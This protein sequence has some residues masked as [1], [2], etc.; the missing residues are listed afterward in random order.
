MPYIKCPDGK[1]Y[2]RYDQSDYA[3]WCICNE[4]AQRDKIFTECMEDPTCKKEYLHNQD[5][6]KSIALF[7]SGII[8]M[9]LI[10]IFYRTLKTS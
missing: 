5:V 9:L 8:V 3:E 10:F 4:Q 6:S 1:T 2:S 7:G